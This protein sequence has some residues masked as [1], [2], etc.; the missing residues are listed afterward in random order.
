MKVYVDGEV[1]AVKGGECVFLP[2]RT[3]H[4]WLITSEQIHVILLVV[5]GGFLDAINQMN[6]PAKR[7]EVPADGETV[8]YATVDLTE[9]IKVFEQHG[10]R[11]LTAEEIRTEMPQYPL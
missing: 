3:P 11:F 8:T 9:T 2:R 10:I 7:M 5:P 1:F 6:A 4:A